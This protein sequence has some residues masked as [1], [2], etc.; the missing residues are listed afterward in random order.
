MIVSLS[1]FNEGK[2]ELHSGMYD[3]GRIQDYINKYEK[4]YLVHLLG[5]ELYGEFEAD[6]IL[7]GGFPTEQRFI[8]IFVAFEIDYNLEVIY[9]EGLKE[10]L[11]GFIYYEWVKDLTNQMTSIGNVVPVGENSENPKT[12]YSMMYNRYNE[13]CR[14]YKSV[15]K[16]ICINRADYA[17]YNGRNKQFITWL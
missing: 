10:M 5:A 11:K 9:S 8:D 15:Q 4:K 16:F 7:G 12:L 17:H 2:Y 3:A 6:L 13:A 14:N 1:D